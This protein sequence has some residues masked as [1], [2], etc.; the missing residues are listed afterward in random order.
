MGRL[1]IGVGNLLRRL[2]VPGA[3]KPTEYRDRVTEDHLVVS[4]GPLFVRVSVN[5][6][7]YFS[8]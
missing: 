5:G 7:D 6:R 4:I 8:D 3:I 2:R 1:K